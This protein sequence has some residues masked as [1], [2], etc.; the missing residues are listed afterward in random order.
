MESKIVVFIDLLSVLPKVLES[1]DESIVAFFDEFQRLRKQYNADELIFSITTNQTVIGN[2]KF[3]CEVSN[4]FDT[5]LDLFSEYCDGYEGLSLGH[6]FTKEFDVSFENG[7][8]KMSVNGFRSGYTQSKYVLD[9]D[10]ESSINMVVVCDKNGRNYVDVIEQCL[11]LN[12]NENSNVSLVLCEN[13]AFNIRNRYNGIIKNRLYDSFVISTAIKGH[14]GITHCINIL[15]E[16]KHISLMRAKENIFEALKENIFNVELPRDIDSI[17]NSLESL[18]VE[19]S[20][21]DCVLDCKDPEKPATK[22]KRIILKGDCP[23]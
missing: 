9:I 23:F 1:S 16:L 6:S 14:Y 12:T 8:K 11:E 20:M 21:L 5:V 3:D 10:D 7:I 4:L 18:A 15:N 19:P 13:S 22:T 2:R 17:P